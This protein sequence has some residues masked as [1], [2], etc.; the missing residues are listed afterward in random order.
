M[1][2]ASRGTRL[3]TG[4]RTESSVAPSQSS[5]LQQGGEPG[6]RLWGELPRLDQIEDQALRRTV[7]GARP[8]SVN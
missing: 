5:F 2:G 3:Q 1:T 6:E 8:D 4:R 7:I